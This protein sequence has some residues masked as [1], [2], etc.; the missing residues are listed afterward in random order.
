[1][2]NPDAYARDCTEAFGA[3]IPRVR[4]FLRDSKL[5]VIAPFAPSI[6]LIAASVRQ[7]A[8]TRKSLFFRCI[9]R[10]SLRQ[11]RTRYG[12]FLQ[13]IHTHGAS[14]PSADLMFVPTLGIDLVWH[15]HMAVFPVEYQ[16]DT[17]AYLGRPLQHNDDVEDRAIEQSLAF[18][19]ELWEREF[20]EAYIASERITHHTKKAS[21]KKAFNNAAQQDANTGDGMQPALFAAVAYGAYCGAHNVS[22]ASCSATSMSMCGTAAACGA[23]S[24]ACGTGATACGGGCGGG[25]C[26]GGSSCGT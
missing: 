14:K 9:S 18:T 10:S 5:P 20:H 25:G 6:D 8:F 19:S 7:A 1:M 26:G 23:G 11:L 12:R 4:P 22:C 15:T 21:L 3:V 13:L 2:L 16:R 17:A 24:S